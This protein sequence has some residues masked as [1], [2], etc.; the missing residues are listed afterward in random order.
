MFLVPHRY[1]SDN[2]L[3]DIKRLTSAS[4]LVVQAGQA[5]L[6]STDILFLSPY[7][8]NKLCQHAS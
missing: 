7:M 6:L 2:L 3:H 8:E 1:I 5:S 4:C